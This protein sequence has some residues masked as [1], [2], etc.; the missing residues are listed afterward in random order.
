MLDY[1]LTFID[2]LIPPFS[3]RKQYD[4]LSFNFLY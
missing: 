4:Y 3:S 1:H 2:L